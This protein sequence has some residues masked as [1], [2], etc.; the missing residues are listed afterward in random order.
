MIEE[1]TYIHAKGAAG[2]EEEKGTE[3]ERVDGGR[4]G[5]IKSSTERKRHVSLQV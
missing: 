3:L 2:W 1:K 4:K 5:Q